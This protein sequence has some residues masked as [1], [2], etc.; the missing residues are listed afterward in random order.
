MATCLKIGGVVN[1]PSV[2]EWLVK[3]VTERDS[4]IGQ[5]GAGTIVHTPGYALMWELDEDGL[6]WIAI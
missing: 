5:V 6:S 2:Q 3:D 4:L 1:N